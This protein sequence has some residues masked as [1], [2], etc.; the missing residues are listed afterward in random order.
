[1]NHTE[2]QCFLAAAELLSFSKA[3]EKLFLSRQAVSRHV[4]NLEAQLETKLFIRNSQSL[5]L[6]E[7]GKLFYDFFDGT[8]QR[9]L[10]L[11][12]SRKK[13]AET[14]PVV[15]ACLEGINLPTRIVDVFFSVARE[16]GREVDLQ[17]YD[18]H[19]L[20]ELVETGSQDFI[21]SYQGPRLLMYTEYESIS[22]ERVPMVL[23]AS[24][25]LSV[26]EPL[27]TEAYQN[28]PVV[29]WARKGQPQEQAIQKCIEHCLD[30]G[31]YCRDVHV[32]P[33]RDTARMEIESG[34]GVGVCTA[35]DRL[36]Y[37]PTVHTL[38]LRG[39][40]TIACMWRKKEKSPLIRAIAAALGEL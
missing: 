25:G 40:S 33:N 13:S 12:A 30:F 9:W 23:V 7:E 3:G 17:S 2:V 28:F 22:L 4:L 5:S 31:F 34:R 39:S 26:D 38:P 19:D 36:A 35:I 16:H 32:A 6:T 8:R 24:K 10:R 1:M 20:T 37:S 14:A 15:V 21:L 27:S 11:Q 29:T 18:M